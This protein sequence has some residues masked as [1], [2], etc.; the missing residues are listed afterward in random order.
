MTLTR[1]LHAIQHPRLA[2]K[3]S[4]LVLGAVFITMAGSAFVLLSR[5]RNQATSDL[6]AR[7]IAMAKLIAAN[8][9]FAI[10]TSNT[11]GLRPLVRQ[12]DEMEDVAYIR[13]ERASQEL[14]IDQRLDRAFSRATLPALASA[15]QSLWPVVRALTV[16]TDD[17]LDVVVPVVHAGDD[18]LGNEL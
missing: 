13:V 12:L 11:D 2:L 16:S 9:E 1:A 14:V 17:V 4:A 7:A 6:E 5:E 8:S 10:Y 18:L 3:V 15:N